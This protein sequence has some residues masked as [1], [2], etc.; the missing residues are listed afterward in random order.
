MIRRGEKD[1]GLQSMG[2]VLRAP[3]SQCPEL[4]RYAP[5]TAFPAQGLAQMAD[6]MELVR[7]K[8][9]PAAHAHASLDG[10]ASGHEPARNGTSYTGEPP[11]PPRWRDRR[12]RGRLTRRP[13]D[14]AT[15]QRTLDPRHALLSAGSAGVLRIRA[16]LLFEKESADSDHVDRESEGLTI[17]KKAEQNDAR[18]PHKNQRPPNRVT[19][20]R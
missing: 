4:V 16:K 6:D 10:T 8:S 14:R 3:E 2:D 11:G 1:C 5:V 12:V 17:T 19:P 18:F 20:H 15:G 13:G 9:P 7:T